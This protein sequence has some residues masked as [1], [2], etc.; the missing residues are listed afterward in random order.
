MKFIMKALKIVS[1]LTAIGLCFTLFFINTSAVSLDKNGSI[2]LHVSDLEEKTPLEGTRFRL[3]YFAAAYKND[4]GV[5]YSYV[6]P[7]EDCDMD[8]NNLQDAY[9]PVHLSYF[10]LTHD[11]PFTEKASD[12]KGNIVFDNL[13]PGV[14]LIFATEIVEGYFLPSPFVVNIP[15]YDHENKSWEYDVNATPKMQLSGSDNNG[16]TTHL[17]VKK[18][19]IDNE[20]IPEKITVSL[21]RDL[22]EIEKIELSE[23]NKWYYRWDNLDATHT[24]NIVESDAPEGYKVSYDFSANTVIITNTKD[25]STEETTIPT[26]ETTLPSEVTTKPEKPTEPTDTTESTTKPDKL[27]HTGQLNW[28]I[29]IFSIA[30]LIF[31]SIGWAILKFGKKDEENA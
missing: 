2:T 19:W 5:G 27:I 28:P 6:I 4:D 29:P 21:L 14:Y 18:I 13:T 7:Y 10:A 25:D 15:I 20:N 31:F 9:L 16:E 12:A 26:E 1:M 24:W 22:R 23:S 17:S 8:M 3:Y 30:G 11:L